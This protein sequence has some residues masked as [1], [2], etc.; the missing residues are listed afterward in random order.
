MERVQ[1]IFK[2]TWLRLCGHAVHCMLIMAFAGTQAF[3]Q[4]TTVIKHPG[5][6]QKKW[7]YLVEA[8]LMFPNMNGT[9]GIGTL[10]D[11]EV[12]AN[13]GDV[14]S[15]LQIG[16]MLYAEA[17][18]DKWAIS[19]DI[20]YM[21]LAQDIKTGTVIK[22]GE[23][24]AKQFAWELAGMRRL[25]PMLEAGV[26]LRVNT[27]KMDVNLVQS[28]VGGST[29]NR[30]KSLTETWVDPF[31]VA[32]IKSDPAKKFIYQLRADIG[33]FGIGADLAWQIQAYAGYRFSRLLQIT[34]GYR[35]LGVDYEKG[36]GENRFLYNMDTFG[37]VIRFG[38]N[39]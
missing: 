29:T 31:F 11:V 15:N 28:N 23:A 35:V 9:T 27:L 4:D 10:P 36:S 21:A 14:F 17:Y 22:S 34:A 12:D 6:S 37:P 20:I 16:A 24:K 19:S 13:P 39:F 30:G 38:F 7:N 2:K 1:F 25:L 5:A 18:S 3:A 32:R 33:G 8:Y 26:G